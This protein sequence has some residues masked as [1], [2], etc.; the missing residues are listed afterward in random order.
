MVSFLADLTSDA[1]A[2]QQLVASKV[3][4]EPTVSY[5]DLSDWNI[6][7]GEYYFVLDRSGSMSGQSIET[8]KKALILFLRSLPPGSKFNIISF[9]SNFEWMFKT[10]VDYEQ[11][12]LETTIS[13]I[14]TF[15]A[16]FGGTEIYDPLQHIFTWTDMSSELDK[17]VYL[18][19]DGQVSNTDK[20]VQLIRDN[21]SKFTVYSVGVGSSVS[22]ELVVGWAKAGNGSYFFVNNSAAGLEATVI[23]ALSLS[24]YPCMHIKDLNIECNGSISM[25]PKEMS[26]TDLK[27]VHSEHLTYFVIFNK[28]E[29]DKLEG[30]LRLNLF[31]P[32]TTDSKLIEFDLSSQCVEI[33]GDSIFKLAAHNRIKE[34]EDQWDRDAATTMS[35]K[36]QVASCYTSFFAAERL[37]DS[38]TGIIEYNKL[39]ETDEVKWVKHYI[40]CS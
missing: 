27:V 2:R 29:S 32:D 20:V 5:E 31:R 8:A 17:H 38:S 37:T 21:N 25:Q 15:S 39:A 3:D 10:A 12:V 36:Y 4:T 34:F 23:N 24:F 16:D 1:D 11:E 18:L 19:T 33:E 30:V 14:Q 22:T 6:R 40:N 26:G 13:K 35:V 9:G 28:L 7:S